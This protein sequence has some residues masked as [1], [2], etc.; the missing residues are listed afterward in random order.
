MTQAA[1]TT[2]DR[3]VSEP[4]DLESEPA[5]P[6]IRSRQ[7]RLTTAD[8]PLLVGLLLALAPAVLMARRVLGSTRLPYN[9]YWPMIDT[10]LGDDGGLKWRGVFQLRNEHPIA[11]PKLEYFAV[12]KLANGSNVVLGLVVIGIVCLTVI[13]LGMLARNTENFSRAQRI[14]IVVAGSALLFT[15]RGSWYFVK[16]MS[17]AAWLTAHLFV[18][19]AFVAHSKQRRVASIVFGVLASISY[20]TGLAIWPALVVA[21][22]IRDRSIIKQWATAATGAVVLLVYYNEYSKIPVNPWIVPPT[23]A[24]R[25]VTAMRTLG[26]YLRAA[27]DS[28]TTTL[29]SLVVG[30]GLL[31]GVYLAGRIMLRD[32]LTETF[33]GTTAWIGL[34]IHTLVGGLLLGSSRP[35][36]QIDFAAGRYTVFGAMLCLSVFAMLLA[37]FPQLPRPEILR[38]PAFVGALALGL[39]VL[40]AGGQFGAEKIRYT[41]A[42]QDTLEGALVLDLAKESALWQG[43]FERMPPG[44]SQLMERNDQVPFDR[45]HELGCGRLGQVLGPDDLDRS[46]KLPGAAKFDTSSSK[47]VPG[48]AFIDGYV[49]NG[50]LDVEC[51]VVVGDTGRVR[52]TGGHGGLD[53]GYGMN[54]VGPG[55]I[56][57][58]KPGRTY[59]RLISHNGEELEVWVLLEGADTFRQV[60]LTP[61]PS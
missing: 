8:W 52:G 43:G 22:V 24:E 12:A 37:V 17:G 35:P 53:E 27:D 59:F 29:G 5:Q 51:V 41:R 61:R 32:D 23:N 38:H 48:S 26:S 20:G 58:A 34:F 36:W 49:D 57:G 18:I 7:R 56:D 30:L 28:L 31:L 19:A 6:V 40:G 47:F 16:S 33:S 3:R 50:S 21:G 14:A 2:A 39:Y 46:A 44:L 45:A 10:I 55:V 42:N 9:D 60:P 1:E 25:L 4:D 11:I 54:T 15:P 13:L